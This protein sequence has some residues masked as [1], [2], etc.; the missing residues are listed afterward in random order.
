MGQYAFSHVDVPRAEEELSVEVA[1]LNVIHVGDHDSPSLTTRH[2]H[3]CKV[4]QKLTPE[5]T[6]SHLVHGKDRA[7]WMLVRRHKHLL[8]V[9]GQQL[10]VKRVSTSAGRFNS[11]NHS[12]RT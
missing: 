4:L 10:Q 6:S 1:L 3:H 11:A 12:T 5:S 9:A 7:H 2:A 8:R